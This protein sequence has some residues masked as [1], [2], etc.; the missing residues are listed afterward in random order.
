MIVSV[1]PCGVDGADLH[2]LAADV[3]VGLDG[4]ETNR[5]LHRPRGLRYEASGLGRDLEIEVPQSVD[6]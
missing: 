2:A 3:H 5:A 6:G 4:E 1:R